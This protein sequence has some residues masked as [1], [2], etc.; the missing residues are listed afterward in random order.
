M[1]HFIDSVILSFA[2]D[3]LEQFNHSL[4]VRLCD[5]VQYDLF[6]RERSI[7]VNHSFVND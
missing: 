2:N 4:E 5:S 7:C 3:S 1:I 6:V